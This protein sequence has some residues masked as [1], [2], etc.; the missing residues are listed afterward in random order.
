MRFS[1]SAEKYFHFLWGKRIYLII[2]AKQKAKTPHSVTLVSSFSCLLFL[3]HLSPWFLP[4]T[5]GSVE[6]WICTTDL[7]HFF[8]KWP[9]WPPFTSL[10]INHEYHDE[11]AGRGAPWF[12]NCVLLIRRNSASLVYKTLSHDWTWRGLS[13]PS[14]RRWVMKHVLSLWKFVLWKRN[15]GAVDDLLSAG[16]LEF[17]SN[18]FWITLV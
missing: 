17:R 7:R 16:N 12:Q 10:P 6:N 1:R 13:L 8:I 3:P 2:Q 11:G 5:V 4:G 18:L 15:K 9:L 14:A